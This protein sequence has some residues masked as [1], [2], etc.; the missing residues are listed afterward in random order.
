MEKYVISAS[1]GGLS[2]RVNSLTSS[3]RISERT[4]RNLLLCWPKDLVCNCNFSDLFENKIKEISKEQLRGIIKNN[5]VQ[6]LKKSENVK[7]K[8][9]FVIV[10]DGCYDDFSKE[11]LLFKFE[12]IE[13]R[14]QKEIYEALKK[15]KIKPNIQNIVNKFFKKNFK[16]EV[17]GLHIRRGDY[18]LLTHNI[19]GISSNEK[20]IE[21]IKK[22]I[23]INPKIKFFIATED[24]ET[25][26]K[27]KK[28][29]GK[30]IVS[31][32]KKTNVKEEEG[33]IKEA[34]VDILLLSKCKEIFGSFRS[35][36]TELAWFLGECKLKVKIIA[37]KKGVEA[38][39]LKEKGKNSLFAKFKK[40]I[41]E[42]ITPLHVRILK[43]VV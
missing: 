23:A 17:I 39:L 8:R 43:E 24:K 32:P 9:K 5:L 20:F 40:I 29:F 18:K 6:V 21:E 28:I 37:D 36:F 35:T 4:K 41:Y 42:T 19:G 14:T 3:I 34:L 7:S 26:E 38:Y 30:R 15:L 1:F 13:K 12:K 25:E 33:A 16:N 22:E 11:E 2:N 31:Y 10:N 27:F